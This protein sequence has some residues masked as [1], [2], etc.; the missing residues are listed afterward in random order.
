MIAYLYLGDG[1]GAA[2]VTDGEV[3]RGHGGLAGEIAHVLTTGTDGR[4]VPFTDV[5]AELGLRRPGSAAI[6]SGRLLAAVTKSEAVRRTLGRA[7]HGALAA[8]VALADPEVVV[9]GG[10]WGSD[11][12]VGEIVADA[13]ARL[14]VPVPVRAAAVTAEPSLAGA[15]TDALHRLRA[16]IISAARETAT[17]ALP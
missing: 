10:P 5:F 2:V 8:L 9:L 17:A 4:A 15:R 12:A 14:P 7:V 11:P 1:L 13:A 3:R 6:D 16:A